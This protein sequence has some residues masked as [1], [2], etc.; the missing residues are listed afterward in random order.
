MLRGPKFRLRRR[1]GHWWWNIPVGFHTEDSSSL[2][3]SS[4]LL[5]GGPDRGAVLGS[6]L[7]TPERAC[8]AIA[9]T[10]VSPLS[11]VQVNPEHVV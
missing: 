4:G 6:V 1:S 9:S 11:V 3:S 5:D 10:S 7:V 8:V 2:L